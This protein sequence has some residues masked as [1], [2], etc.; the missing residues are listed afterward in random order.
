[1]RVL[2]IVLTEAAQKIYAIGDSHAVAIAQSGGFVNLATNG[3][4]A[5]SADNDGA[6]GKVP[7]GS[8]VVLS[9]GANDMLNSNKAGVASRIQTL[10]D[11]LNKKK[12]KVFYVL[13][14]ETDNPKFAKDRNQLRNQV[15]SAVGS[16]ATILDMGALHYDPKTKKDGIH[17]P[18]SWYAGAAKKV[19]GAPSAPTPTAPEATPSTEQ[20]AGKQVD[21]KD[22]V[23]NYLAGGGAAGTAS[24]LGGSLV[25][26]IRDMI[27]GKTAPAAAPDTGTIGKQTGSKN[28]VDPKTVK[29]YLLGKGFTKNQAAGWLSNI[30]HECSFNFGAYVANDNGGP[31]GGCFGFH[32]STK[33]KNTRNFTKMVNYAGPNWGANW[34]GQLDY[35]ISTPE[36]RKYLSINFKTPQAASEWWTRNYERP[37]KMELRVAQRNK[38]A[39][40]YAE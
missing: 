5:F 38:A 8:T 12:C 37:A 7:A 6:V 30:E 19:A 11:T 35:A 18:M 21:I 27:G 39:A 25:D 3:R 24:I 34:Q 20:P 1:M 16:S 33:D 26:K 17:A 10:I 29:E 40:R 23:G 22:L 13:F 28:Y 2:D 36:G 31:S 4:S 32:D 15:S 14:A 9:A